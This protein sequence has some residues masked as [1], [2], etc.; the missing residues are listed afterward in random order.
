MFHS[1]Y[2]AFLEVRV[3]LG[4]TSRERSMSQGSRPLLS[5]LSCFLHPSGEQSDG[6]YVDGGVLLSPLALSC[7]LQSRTLFWS[8]T[9][10]ITL[11]KLQPCSQPPAP[12]D[13]MWFNGLWEVSLKPN[14]WQVKLP[15]LGRILIGGNG[16]QW[17][18]YGVDVPQA[19]D[20]SHGRANSI[21][22]HHMLWSESA[23]W[24][25]LHW[26][27]TLAPAEPWPRP[28]IQQLQVTGRLC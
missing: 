15:T 16:G 24:L 4:T 6:E 3:Q 5:P 27:S 13:C 18:V 2:R 20:C 22:D 11:G 21:K 7:L 25:W 19:I 17:L 14:E 10:S 9:P 26:A 23:S 8:V 12:H 28:W 1:G